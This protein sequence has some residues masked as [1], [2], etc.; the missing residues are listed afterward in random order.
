MELLRAFFFISA[1]GPHGAP[2]GPI[3]ALWAPLEP[4]WGPYGARMDPYWAHG[5]LAGRLP[6]RRPKGPAGP[7]GALGPRP[8]GRLG[9][10]APAGRPAGP[11]GP[12]PKTKAI[13]CI[14]EPLGLCR[15]ILIRL[16][17]YWHQNQ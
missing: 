10:H 5:A 15:L 9:P 12:G 17:S 3:G 1:P 16:Q 8:A 13:L 6:S 14:W 11:R 4:H 2:L 7:T